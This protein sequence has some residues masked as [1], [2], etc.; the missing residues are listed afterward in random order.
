VGEDRMAGWYRLCVRCFYK[1]KVAEDLI[2]SFSKSQK[3]EN[4]IFCV[5][6]MKLEIFSSGSTYKTQCDLDG[7]VFRCLLKIVF[8]S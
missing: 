3:N 5:F 8:L 2:I 7:S 4:N 1:C 6:F